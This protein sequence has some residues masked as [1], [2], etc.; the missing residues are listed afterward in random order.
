[1]SFENYVT[2]GR[3]GLRVSDLCLGTAAFGEEGGY[4]VS[5]EVS[6]IVID[7]YV[8]L[9]G[10]FLD[11]ANLYSKGHAEAIIGD[12]LAS[13]AGRRH[14]MVIA[15][16][17]FSNMYPGDPNGG[18]ASRR[19]IIEQCEES[20][21]RLRTDYIDLY[22]M[23]C[24][25]PLTPIE[26]SMSALDDLVRRGKVRYIGCSDA[27][28]WK[29]AQAQTL[30]QFRGWTPFIAL[31]LEY[32]LMER[33]IEGEHVPLAH[34]MG[35]GI[36]PWGAL[37]SGVLTGA[38]GVSR[39]AQDVSTRASI[40]TTMKNLSDREARI[41]QTIQRIAAE[42]GESMATIAL[43]WVR[44]QP[45]I[46]VTLFGADSPEQLTENAR[47]AQVAL[48]AAQLAELG[49]ASK[50]QLNFPHAFSAALWPSLAHA[51]A[52]VNG[53]RSGIG[54]LQPQPDDKRF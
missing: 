54:S 18:G 36:L 20:L 27:P 41:L 48:S 17:F 51:G 26:E 19:A 21:R 47:A 38:Y 30:S 24:W 31:E 43:A 13:R 33:T 40:N 3:S 8:S 12:Y 9:G 22:W 14:R 39:A 46:V 53:I 4:G 2:L 25:D 7:R 52:T 23:H 44:A 34:E 1:M 11:T 37:R 5:A 50:P 35:L 45:G 49:Q 42:H 10:N 16:K 29:I 15:T 32:S 6:Q 28:A